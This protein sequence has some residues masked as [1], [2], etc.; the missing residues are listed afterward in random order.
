MEKYI[1]YQFWLTI[2]EVPEYIFG[3]FSQ[4]CEAESSVILRQG[5]VGPCPSPV[6]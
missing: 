2:L 4:G 5:Q 3:S 6:L 1:L